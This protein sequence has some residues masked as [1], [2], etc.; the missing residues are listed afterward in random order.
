MCYHNSTPVTGKLS[1]D[2]LHFLDM[3]A[4]AKD[5][6][7]SSRALDDGTR[8]TSED[9]AVEG[10]VAKMLSGLGLEAGEDY[11]D[12][13]TG[14]KTCFIC[15]K[16]YKKLRRFFDRD[17][18]GNVPDKVL[19]TTNVCVQLKHKVSKNLF[20]KTL[21]KKFIFGT[22]QSKLQYYTVI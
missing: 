15:W 5:C 12:Y 9:R 4:A 10:R 13:L 1:N 20:L 3:E 8:I 19:N 2:T 7:N 17:F 22:S 16:S 11:D 18:I 14:N 21:F 6:F